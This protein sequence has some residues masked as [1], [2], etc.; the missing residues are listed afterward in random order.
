MSQDDYLSNSRSYVYNKCKKMF[1]FKYLDRVKPAAKGMYLDSWE[2]LIRGVV[3][4]AGIE[5]GFLGENIEA[6][7]RTSCVQE[8]AKGLTNDQLN[9]LLVIQN[10]SPIVCRDLLEWLPA[11]D[12]EPV[13]YRGKPMV[14]ARLEWPLAGWKGFLGYADL[15]AKHKPTGR[16]MVLDW[17]T[18]TSFEEPDMDIFNSQFLLYSY[19]LAKM[20]VDIHG[21]L[22]VEAKPTAPK[23]AP[24][25]IREDSGSIDGVRISVDGRFRSTATYRSPTYLANGWKDFEV[26]AKQIAGFTDDQA[27]R[28]LSAFN[29]KSC[30][31]QKLCQAELNGHDVEHIAS[32]S[33]Q[34]RKS[35]IIME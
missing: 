1:K 30:E 29:C 7:I 26:Q 13:M 28:R 9:A 12:W 2:R 15:V 33:Y 18:R 31:F 24:R 27:Y 6:A 35:A 11:T 19:V 25:V 10:E 23:R 22:L 14:E 5:A 34:V 20:G 3:I 4:H 16:V 21:S 17:K 32:T 8:R